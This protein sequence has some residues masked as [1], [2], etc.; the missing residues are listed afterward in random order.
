MRRLPLFAAAFM[1]LATPAA[2][3]VGP[4]AES[5]LAAGFLHPFTGLDHLLAML[6]VGLWAGLACPRA[7][8]IWP[9]TFVA[10]ML[11]G[12]A[13]GAGGAPIGG[14]EGVILASVTALGLAAAL[15][16]K[17]STAAGAAVVAVF[18]LAHG[19]AHGQELPAGVDG[20]TFAAGFVA[21]TAL[22]HLGGLG[23][24]WA[25]L[26]VKAPRLA[27]AAGLGAAAA[28]LALAWIG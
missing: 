22:L 23:L 28:G 27:Q 11:A 5:G 1:M 6:S 24:A 3:H 8:W 7:P 12:F 13:I 15:K 4:H 9:A 26:R 17:V 10:V 14:I 16:L 18:A 20:E 25:T 2:A 19:Y 21:A